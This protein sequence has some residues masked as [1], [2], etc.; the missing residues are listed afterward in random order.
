L[1]YLNIGADNSLTIVH[2]QRFSVN[3]SVEVSLERSM[4]VSEPTPRFEGHQSLQGDPNTTVTQIE[5][6]YAILVPDEK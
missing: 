3:E 4:R 6:D 2:K 1:V 5:C